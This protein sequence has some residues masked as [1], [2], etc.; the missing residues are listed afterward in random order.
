MHVLTNCSGRCDLFHHKE[1]DT[2]D[3]GKL[4]EQLET[5]NRVRTEKQP[6]GSTIKCPKCR[7]KIYKVMNHI[8]FQTG[9]FCSTLQITS[10]PLLHLTSGHMH[11]G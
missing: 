1:K 4:L 3:W 7:Q 5:R 6:V 2:T 11:S 9:T 8:I 10:L